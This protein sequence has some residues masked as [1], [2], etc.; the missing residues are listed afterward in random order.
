MQELNAFR[1]KVML[2]FSSVLAWRFSITPEFPSSFL[3]KDWN[4][5]TNQL[6][7]LWEYC[8]SFSRYITTIDPPLSDSSLEIRLDWIR[9]AIVRL[10][11]VGWAKVAGA[12]WEEKEERVNGERAKVVEM[13]QEELEQRA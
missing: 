3:S 11:S 10:K 7:S 4:Q 13:R 8:E 12:S 6:I 9:P 1:T 2:R 5:H